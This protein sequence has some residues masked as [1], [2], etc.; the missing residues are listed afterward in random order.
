M[1]ETIQDKL[2][3]YLQDALAMERNVQAMLGSMRETT[4]DEKLRLRMERHEQETQNQIERLEGCLDAHGESSSTV[5]DTAA[6][7]GAT[8]KGVFDRVRG[9]KAGRNIRDA[10]IAEHGEIAAYQLLERVATLAGDTRAA[11]VARTNRA[12]EEDMARFLD[13]CWDTAVHESLREEGVL[14]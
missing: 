5:K 6:Q 2:V 7:L 4:P 9:D 10:Y 3:A 13:G 14:A 8:M 12:E 11:E 1:A